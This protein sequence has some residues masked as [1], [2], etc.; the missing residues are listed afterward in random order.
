MSSVKFSADFSV[1]DNLDFNVKCDYAGREQKNPCS[2][3]AKYKADIHHFVAGCEKK[4]KLLCQEHL[5]MYIEHDLRLKRPN[6]FCATC[7]KDND[8]I[9]DITPL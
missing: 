5:N 2:N 8:A 9:T 3:D 7:L 6:V 4:A 1:L